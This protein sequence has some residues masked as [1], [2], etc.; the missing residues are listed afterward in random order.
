[1]DGS[2]HDFLKWE[3]LIYLLDLLEISGE[4]RVA[5]LG[6]EPT[7]HPLF[8]EFVLYALQ[9]KF[10]VNIFSSG[11]LSDQTLQMAARYLSGYHHQELSFVCNIN[12]PDITPPG[13]QKSLDRFLKSFGHLVSPG[14]NIYHHKLDLDF[15]VRL[16]NQYGLRRHIRLGLAN[17]IPGQKNEFLDIEKMPE[18]LERLFDYLPVF[19]K[20]NI[21][22]GFDCGMPL[23][24]FPDEL[25]GRFFKLNNGNLSFGCG[26]AVD[27][28]PDMSV[29]S[30]FP[31]STI[32]KKSVFDFNSLREIVEYF[33]GI[34]HKIRSEA[35]GIFE[36]CDS[37][38][39][40]EKD[41][42]AG[43]CLAHIISNMQNEPKI[44]VPEVYG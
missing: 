12:H 31:L 25:I 9:R 22:I 29:W 41:L 21:S 42:C 40:R 44:R 36:A 35:A 17:P 1:M 7:L 10:H 24:L 18:M 37:C 39:Y 2:S 11:I 43:G 14:Y 26:P 13:E 27:F 32:N 8:T 34:Q 19:E 6:G 28:G 20:F 38:K 15:M 30:C 3:D 16:I 23:C 4:K 5:Y 33:K